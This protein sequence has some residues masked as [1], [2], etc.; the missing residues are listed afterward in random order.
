MFFI[1]LSDRA[2]NLNELSDKYKK[3]THK[4]NLQSTYAKI[5]AIIF[6]III[7]VLVV[8]FYVF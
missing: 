2:Q 7:F 4:L 6:L 3:G 1:A 5:G 8:K